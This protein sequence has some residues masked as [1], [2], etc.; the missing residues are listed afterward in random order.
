MLSCVSVCVFVITSLILA[1]VKLIDKKP[2]PIFGVY[3]RANGFYWFKVFLMF[4]CLCLRKIKYKIFPLSQEY[5]NN[6]DRPQKLAPTSKAVD[7]VFFCNANKDGDYFIVGIARRSNRLVDGFILLK[8]NSLDLGVLESPKIPDTALFNTGEEES[9]EAEGIKITPRIPMKEW[10]IEYNGQL[11]EFNDIT[12]LHNVKITAQFTSN[13]PI[14][15]MDR[16]LDPWEMARSL[17]YEKWSRGYFDNAKEHHQTHYEQYGI[18][19]AKISIDGKVHE[20]VFDSLRDHSIAKNRDWG[21]FKRYGIHFLSTENGDHLTIGTLCM[22]SY[23]SRIKIGYMYNAVDKKIYNIRSSNL[24]LYQF[25]ELG[26]PPKDYAFTFKAGKTE[27]VMQ[28]NIIDS[29]Y[30]YLSKDCEVKVYEQLCTIDINGVKGWGSAEWIYR[31]VEG[32]NVLK[33]SK[34]T[35][36]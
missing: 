33:K 11:K 19:K 15:N 36:K 31:N 20:T 16:D 14:Y 12:K 1:V 26:T 28:V 4:M 24:E 2:G 13:K 23:L 32:R 30:F 10:T 18:V 29:P 5:L 9:Y 22:P 8:L 7:A 34:G 3:Q 27:Y 17:A 6:L 25:G 21:H 35:I